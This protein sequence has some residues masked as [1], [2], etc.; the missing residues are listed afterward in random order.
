MEMERLT[1]QQTLIQPP[2]TQQIIELFIQ[3]CRDRQLT[4]ETIRR[5]QSSIKQYLAYLEQQGS[6][7][8]KADKHVLHDYIRFRYSQGINQTTLEQDLS[9][10]AGL[11]E[12]LVFEDYLERNPVPGVRKRYLR[13][14]KKENAGDDESPRKLLTVEEMSLLI[15][16]VIDT[17]DKTI[18]TVLAKTGVRRGELIAMDVN[19]ID[20]AM[21]SITM[22]RN[23]FKK[24]SGRIVFFDDETARLLK[25]WINQREKINPATPALFI[26]E[27]GLRLNRNG[28][29][30]MVAKYA[31]RVGL[32]NPKSPKPE[33]HVSPHC[34][35]H[36][37]TTHLR[38]AG[39]DREFIK[40]LRGDRRREAIDIYDRIDG[41]E[42][43]RAYLAFIPQLGL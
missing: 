11:Y 15:N 38:R 37:F 43:R 13:R 27:H 19:D 36:W 24:R 26:G 18:M 31:Q 29:Y 20:W 21:Q 33:D 6:S 32:N 42:L 17:R 22:K 28:V 1:H 34:F 41:A 25:R 8:V 7:I 40:T 3:D 5:Y 10:I 39:M 4:P 12:F 9:A 30:S 2:S 35:R 23:R 16:S 14:Y